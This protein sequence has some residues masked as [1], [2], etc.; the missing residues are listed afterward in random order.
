MSEARH[1]NGGSAAAMGTLLG[2]ALLKEAE[3]LIS[4]QGELLDNVETAVGNWVRRQRQALDS[5]SRSIQKIY[6]CRNLLDLLQIQQQFVTDCLHWTAAEVR[7][8]GSDA[9]AVTRTAAGRAGE[10]ARG[11]AEDAR[12][13]ARA[14]RESAPNRPPQE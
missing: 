9:A 10:I 7:A 1:R 12:H 8:L 3:L 13:T 4:A 2:S 14:A 6:E 5:S 11:A